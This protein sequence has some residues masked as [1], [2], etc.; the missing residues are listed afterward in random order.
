MIII[1]YEIYNNNIV[2]NLITKRKLNEMLRYNNKSQLNIS[3]VNNNTDVFEKHRKFSSLKQFLKTSKTE[4][5]NIKS[6]NDNNYNINNKE[7]TLEDLLKEYDEEMKEIN[8]KKKKTFFKRAKLVLEAFDNILIDKVIDTN[9][10]EKYSE[11]EE[12]VFDNALI[13]SNTMIFAIPIFSYLFKRI[14]FYDL[15]KQ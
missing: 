6:E 10:R 1:H 7:E 12:E 8:E 15:P 5:N 14:N 9:I 11:L 3:H 2:S 4:P 13:L